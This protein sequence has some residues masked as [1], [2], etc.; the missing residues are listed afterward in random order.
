[1]SDM[2]SGGFRIGPREI[3]RLLAA[4]L[5]EDA[6]P[7]DLLVARLHEPDK[8]Q[9]VTDALAPRLSVLKSPD[10]TREDIVRWKEEA[11]AEFAR[12]SGDP[13]LVTSTFLDYSA[14]IAAALDRGHGVIS[15]IPSDEIRGMLDRIG[16]LLPGEWS[17]VFA[18]A[19]RRI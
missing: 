3:T 12:A 2:P 8:T 9:W 5:G 18:R 1:M 15:S 10:S 16:P 13:L 17:S 4:V 6:A 11:K 7:L 14:S 19:R